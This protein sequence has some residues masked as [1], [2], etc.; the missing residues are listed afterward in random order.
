[1]ISGQ[2]TLLRKK[3]IPPF[4][5]FNNKIDITIVLC[6]FAIDQRNFWVGNEAGRIEPVYTG[7]GK[8]LSFHAN[9]IS[10][11]WLSLCVPESNELFNGDLK[12][13]P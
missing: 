10:L 2:P 1:M 8:I 9:T 12:F 5:G 11:T 3:D 4:S 7:D 6:T 13:N